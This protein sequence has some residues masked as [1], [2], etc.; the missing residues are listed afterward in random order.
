MFCMLALAKEEVSD[1]DMAEMILSEVETLTSQL[2]GL[3]ENIKVLLLCF[4]L[5]KN[6]F[7]VCFC[8]VMSSGH[9]LNLVLLD[10]INSNC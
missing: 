2:K 8:S 1:A 7:C 4:T 5:Q 10:F 9:F 3:E 6:C